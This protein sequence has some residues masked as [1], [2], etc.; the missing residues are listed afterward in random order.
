MSALERQLAHDLADL[1]AQGLHRALRRV[2]EVAGTRVVVDGRPLINFAANDYLALGAHPAL[3]SAALRAV[4]EFGAGSGA[5]RLLSGSLSP[6]HELEQALADLKGAAAAL[7]FSSGYAAAIGTVGALVGKGDVVILDRL[8]HACLVDAARL[9]GATLRV[10]KHN[11]LNRL[12]EL[13]RWAV[14]RA[15]RATV[16]ITES[17]FSMDGDF[18]PLREI[19]ELKDRHGAWLLVDEAHATGLFG[20]R[21]EG[22]AGELGIADRI[23]VQM[24]TLGKALGAAG[25]FIAGSRPLVDW[26]VNRARS[27][28]FS[29]APPPAQA[30]AARAAVALIQAPTGV[31][32]RRRLWE[33]VAQIRPSL[34]LPE[35]APA[36]AILPLIL[37]PEMEAVRL[38]DALRARGLFVPA[39][40][41]PTVA[42]GQAR[43]RISLSAAHTGEQIEQLTTA[44]AELRPLP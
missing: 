17:V 35:A 37:G 20:A 21:G 16:V 15:R 3:R 18:A 6:H 31:E 33:R 41:Y 11:D 5:A 23:E 40:R 25:G 34:G 4:N 10:F 22:R 26:L 36:S 32:L 24:G 9:S 29:T 39:I 43:L 44:L 14:P 7:T 28:V 19:V 42:R 38:A 13:L 30:A 12:E 27:F 1:E 2:S 8:V